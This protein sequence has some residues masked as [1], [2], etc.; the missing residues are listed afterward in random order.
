VFAADTGASQGD[1]V[2]ASASRRR[3]PQLDAVALGI[4][5]P[6]EFSVRRMSGTRRSLCDTLHRSARACWMAAVALALVAGC[7][8][9]TSSTPADTP[10]STP[11]LDRLAALLARARTDLA[12]GVTRLDLDGDW[13]REWVRTRPSKGLTRTTVDLDGNGLGE[14]VWEASASS[15]SFEET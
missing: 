11:E 10:A 9:G 2:R 4:H 3:L 7:E 15:R 5:H 12:N 13:R 8:P 1:G 6:A 14:L